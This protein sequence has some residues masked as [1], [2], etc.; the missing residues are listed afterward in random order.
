[1]EVP[2]GAVADLLGK[3]GTK[4][5]HAHRSDA[6]VTTWLL[7]QLMPILKITAA[8]EENPALPRGL[9]ARLLPDFDLLSMSDARLN[10]QLKPG[11]ADVLK[12]AVPFV[13]QELRFGPIKVKK[14][15]A[16]PA[17]DRKAVEFAW[18]KQLKEVI[19]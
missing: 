1:M 16:A 13:H 11:A 14:K 9:L 5:V 10:D 8:I 19:A 17:V 15:K 6:V 4:L 12:L 2:T 18:L 3:R 7:K